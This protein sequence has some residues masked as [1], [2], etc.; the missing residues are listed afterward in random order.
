MKCISIK[1][2]MLTILSFTLIKGIAICQYS[3]PEKTV[4]GSAL[5]QIGSSSGSGYFLQDTSELYLVSARHVLMDKII[6]SSTKKIE[7]K[8]KSPVAEVRWYAREVDVSTP[9]IM[10]IDL[11]SLLSSGNAK[12]GETEED[13]YFI[14]R[15]AS[16]E[17]KEDYLSVNY[18]SFI[19]RPGPSSRIEGFPLNRVCDFKDITLGD[20]VFMV[21]YPKSLGLKEI[22]QYDFNRPLLRK[23]IV[24]G[25]DGNLKNVIIDCPSYGGNSGGAIFEVLG[26]ELRLI[27]VVSAFIPLEEVW[28]NPNYGIKNIELS[29]SGYSVVIPIEKVILRISDIKKNTFR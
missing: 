4:N 16:I 24:A 13:D 21:G 7:F 10:I 18:S 14:V 28:V 5:I 2:L 29:N 22:P 23:G 27:G 8:L 9:N 26:R 6:N 1:N 11:N 25:K 15:I 19:N 17:Q 20:E 3:I 12:Y